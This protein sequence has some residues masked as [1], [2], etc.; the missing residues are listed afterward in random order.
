MGTWTAE[1]ENELL[2]AAEIFER[3]D[4]SFWR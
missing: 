4:E 1:Q 3:V 2:K